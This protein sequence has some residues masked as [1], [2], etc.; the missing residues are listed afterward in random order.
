V[1]GHW[2]VGIEDGGSCLEAVRWGEEHSTDAGAAPA[3]AAVAAAAAAALEE[4]GPWELRGRVGSLV[5]SRVGSFAE[6]GEEDLPGTAAAGWDGSIA[7]RGTSSGE[8]GSRAT[9][10]V[11]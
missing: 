3:A 7:G 8:E 10:T 6:G 2:E 9:E 1:A 5:G 4:D 11:D